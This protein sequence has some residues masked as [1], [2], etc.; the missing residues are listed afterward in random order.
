MIKVLI[1]EDDPRIALLHQSMV[2][3]V[4]GF[5]VISIANT[6]AELQ[7]YITLMKPDLVLLD[8]Y[9]PDGNGIDFLSWMQNN[10]I[11]TDVILITAAKEMA[12][13]EKSL[14]YGVF[15][16][17]IK[18]IMFYR[19]ATSLQKYQTHKE[20]VVDK[21]ELSQSKVDAFFNKTVQTQKP[22][23]VGLPKGIDGITLEKIL[24]ALHQSESFFSANEIALNLGINR[25]TAR[26]Y[27]EYLVSTC[28][29]E[30]DS[31][32]GTVGRPERKYRLKTA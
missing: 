30:V 8:V 26:R 25:T 31:L 14:R 17:L 16:Y 12:S 22:L 7:E 24:S 10:A 20:R 23:H 29:V 28:K 5:E 18:P 13:L 6:I 21:E 4:A 15:D 9:F 11:T 27:L 1:A 32:Y 19:F 3:K 2:E